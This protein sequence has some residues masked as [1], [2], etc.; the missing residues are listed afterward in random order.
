MFFGLCFS[1]LG[2]F[3]VNLLNDGIL[4]LM[5]LSFSTLKWFSLNHNDEADTD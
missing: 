4:D 2:S 5:L 1:R 3:A